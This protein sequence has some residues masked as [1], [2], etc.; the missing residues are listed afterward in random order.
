[1]GGKVSRNNFEWVESDEPHATRRSMI[2]KKYPQ[3]KQLMKVDARFKWIVITLV[4]IQFFSF[5]LLRNV[6]SV[7]ML[8]LFGYCFGGIIN[9]SLTLAIH[10]ISHNHAFGHSYPLA[11]KLLGIFAS[12][13]TGLP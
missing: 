7:W 1:M 11:N 3:I 10:D 9:H 13:P 6:N 5:Y 4:L 2:L 12:L 8:C